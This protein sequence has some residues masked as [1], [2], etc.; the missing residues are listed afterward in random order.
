MSGFNGHILGSKPKHVLIIVDPPKE[1]RPDLM[2]GLIDMRKLLQVRGFDPVIWFWP[3]P[4]AVCVC[5]L[6]HLQP[7]DVATIKRLISE[8]MPKALAPEVEAAPI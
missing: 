4:N 6:D 8:T 7:T 5:D 3:I 1:P 2:A